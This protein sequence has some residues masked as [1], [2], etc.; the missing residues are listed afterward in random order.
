MKPKP[1]YLWMGRGFGVWLELTSDDSH[2]SFHDLARQL[3]AEFDGTIV[4]QYPP[5]IHDGEKE[6]WTL[7][8]DGK[9]YLLMRLCGTGTALGC[10]GGDHIRELVQIAT[11]LGVR[12]RIGWRWLAWEASGF[13]RR[14]MRRRNMIAHNK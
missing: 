3:C 6:Y 4:E 14:I 8:L 9:N 2:A 10:N 5:G 13:L 1:P 7:F 11:R 12:K